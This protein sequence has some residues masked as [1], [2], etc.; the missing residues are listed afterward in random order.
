VAGGREAEPMRFG[1]QA[2]MD[3]DEPSDVHTVASTATNVSDISQTASLLH[4]NRRSD[5]RRCRLCRRGQA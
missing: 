2:H 3:A 5:R 1:M 4:G